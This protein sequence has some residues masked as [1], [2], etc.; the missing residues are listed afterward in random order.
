M[1]ALAEKGEHAEA[2]TTLDTIRT[3][4]DHA[5][6]ALGPLFLEAKETIEQVMSAKMAGV[7]EQVLEKQIEIEKLIAAHSAS[8]EA[9]LGAAQQE[10]RRLE[11]ALSDQVKRQNAERILYQREVGDLNNDKK[12]L[13]KAL[14]DE[15][16][17]HEAD[18]TSFATESAEP[19]GIFRGGD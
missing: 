5:C 18:R 1:S 14:A 16:Q 6:G 2:Y 7:R 3:A 15:V 10:K 8:E 11:A 13:E 4:F 19:E 9:L 17:R 12:L